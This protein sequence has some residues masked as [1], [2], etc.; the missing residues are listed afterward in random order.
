MRTGRKNSSSTEAEAL[1]AAITRLFEEGLKGNAALRERALASLRTGISP[2]AETYYETPRHPQQLSH[3]WMDLDSVDDLGKGLAE[4]WKDEPGLLAL[5]PEMARIAG[6]LK[7]TSSEQS[8]ELDS[9][10]Y[11]MY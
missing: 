5:V 6:A 11:V 9:F 8:A 4:L 2:E 3:Q 7:E 1:R 10:I